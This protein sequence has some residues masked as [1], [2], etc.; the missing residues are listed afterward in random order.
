MKVIIRTLSRNKYEKRWKFDRLS[1]RWL[2]KYFREDNTS[3]QTWKDRA[4]CS[5]SCPRFNVV[6]RRKS[7][8]RDLN[9]P[10]CSALLEKFIGSCLIFPCGFASYKWFSS[11]VYLLNSGSIFL[12]KERETESKNGKG[13][14]KPGSVA[15]GYLA[16]IH[17][18][19]RTTAL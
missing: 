11:N 1:R 16:F 18:P 10:R 6:F 9:I 12:E 7:G 14:R 2:K 19:F 4:Q 15:F 3:G 17:H 5:G 13:G 8:G